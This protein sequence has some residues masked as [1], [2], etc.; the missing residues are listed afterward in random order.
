MT[1]NPEYDTP[2]HLKKYLET[3]NKAF[4][5]ISANPENLQKIAKLF[6]VSYEEVNQQIKLPAPIQVFQKLYLFIGV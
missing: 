2:E 5:G 1:V 4:I 6:K 3:F